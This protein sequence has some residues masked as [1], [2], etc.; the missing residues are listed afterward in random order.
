MRRGI[1]FGI[2][3]L[4]C[5]A[6]AQI[7]SII[8]MSL[9]IKYGTIIGDKWVISFFNPMAPADMVYWTIYAVGIGLVLGLAVF[10][11]HRWSL[12]T[13]ITFIV[14]GILGM[15]ITPIFIG[16]VDA[17]WSLHPS[18]STIYAYFAP[19]AMAANV[20][21]SFAA[22]AVG[23]FLGRHLMSREHAEEIQAVAPA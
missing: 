10:M 12:S 3:A 7:G 6:F 16:S 20:V 22:T 4:A 19:D 8:C 13:G 17:L 23:I 18:V 9:D 5:L 14:A 15:F 21:T 2:V 11:R 1:F